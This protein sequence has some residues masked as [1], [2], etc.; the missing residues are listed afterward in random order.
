M[1]ARV[2]FC[3][4]K[5]L[6][7]LLH[8]TIN[9]K[10]ASLPRKRMKM[11]CVH[12]IGVVSF[13]IISPSTLIQMNLKTN[14][15]ACAHYVNPCVAGVQR[16]RAEGKLNSSA[17][18]WIATIAISSHFAL[19]FSFPLPSLCT[20]VTQ[21]NNGFDNGFRVHCK[22]YAR[23]ISTAKRECQNNFTI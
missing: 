23:N 12:T 2:S 4:N 8:F 6:H 20:L 10:T 13:I 5:L 22:L 17:I 14:D 15:R 18:V 9:L 19:E 1:P 11:F 16:G 3:A 21:A 7:L